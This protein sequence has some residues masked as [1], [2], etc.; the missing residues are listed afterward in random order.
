MT[1]VA[2]DVL[3]TSMNFLLPNNVQYQNVFHHKRTGVA[4][5]TDAA[6]ITAIQGWAEVML[7]EIEAHVKV[8]TLEQLCSVDRVAFT[9]VI[10]E[11]VENIGTFIPDF[12]P[13]AVTDVCPNQVSPFIVF[14]TS[15]PK[16]VGRKFLFPTLEPDQ[17][18]GV[19]AAP[20]VASIVAYADDAV[21]DINLA[22]L[23]DL[24]PG[25]PRTGLDQWFEFT[26]A[27]VT[28]LLGTQRRRRPGTGA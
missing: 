7:D 28:D 5:I 2:G 19:I 26:L 1:I 11:V 14:K 25:V 17:D 24:V 15:R 20:A 27:I 16:T 6:H 21:N 9:G 18:Q 4:V 22:A 10:W 23:N 13:A 3:R 8:G 12:T